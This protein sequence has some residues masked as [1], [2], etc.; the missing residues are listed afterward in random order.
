MLQTEV[1][2]QFGRECQVRQ[3][4]FSGPGVINDDPEGFGIPAEF[5]RFG[6]EFHLTGER[7]R[8]VLRRPVCRGCKPDVM[9]QFIYWKDQGILHF[10]INDKQERDVSF[11]QAVYLLDHGAKL[12]K[13]KIIRDILYFGCLISYIYLDAKKILVMENKF[14][15]LCNTS[16]YNFSGYPESINLIKNPQKRRLTGEE[17][18]QLISAFD[19]VGI[20][21]GVEP[22]NNE[23]LKAAKSLKV[24]S[25]CGIDLETIDYRAARR[26][27]IIVTGTHLAP[28]IPAAELALA[29]ILNLTRNLNQLDSMVRKNQWERKV[30]GLLK[31][32][33]VG[34]IGCGIL[35]TR[36]SSLLAAFDCNLMGFDPDVKM[37]AY[38]EMVSFDFLLRNADIITL[39]MP[40]RE[41]HYHLINADAIAK[42]KTGVVIVNT[43]RSGLIDEKALLAALDNKKLGGVALDVFEEEPYQGP[44]INYPENTILTPHVGSFAG[45]YRFDIEKEAME[46]LLKG[47]KKKG[48]TV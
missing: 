9:R 32:K 39:H 40:M 19:P 8:A 23:T 7:D 26:L 6:L 14:N 18:D 1:R 2:C 47:L 15:V 13:L 46:N 48:I 44:L 27:G 24:I 11:S 5:H 45:T 42:M 35:G 31:G 29:M 4:G 30:T 28:D 22:I 36:V 3:I 12:Q 37:H 34:V 20:I 21:A 10:K 17:L 41:E 43:S 16:S 38:C 33:M 25:R